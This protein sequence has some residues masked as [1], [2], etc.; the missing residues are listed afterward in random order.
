MRTYTV[1]VRC[2][3]DD[4]SNNFF[5]SYMDAVDYIKKYIPHV[6]GMTYAKIKEYGLSFY[7]Y[8]PEGDC[9]YRE[10]RTFD[11]LEQS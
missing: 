2:E 1:S 5:L 9:V 11:N 4:Y 6:N 3:G 10:A 8:N 7:V